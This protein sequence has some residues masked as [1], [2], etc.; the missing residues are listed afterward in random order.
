VG[1]QSFLLSLGLSAIAISAVAVANTK[2]LK[3]LP[4]PVVNSSM[5][6]TQG[7]QIAVFAGGCFWGMEAVFEHTKGVTNVV[8]GFAGGSPETANYERVSGGDTGHAEAVQITY[9]PTQV[10]YGE[11]LKIFFAVAHDPTQRDRQGP[12]WGRQYRSAI[13]FA[14]NDQKQVAQ[15]YI[16]QLTQAKAFSSPIVTELTPLTD[17]YP[18][19]EYHQN[20][21]ARNPTYPYVVVHDLPKLEELKKQF[22]NSYQ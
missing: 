9:N 18:A 20:F 13:F 2:T 15:R 16:Q 4:E 1:S 5:V 6:A 12:D 3:S 14:N 21:I 17:F 19:E 7:K 22:P 11:L 10:T 8:S